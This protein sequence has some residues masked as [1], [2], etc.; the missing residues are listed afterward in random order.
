MTEQ[1]LVEIL[2]GFARARILVVG[3]FFLDK[4]LILDGDL[5]EVSL[6]T[7]LD[8]YQVVEKRL[9]PGAAGTVTANLAALDA[10]AVHALGMIGRDGEGRELQAG[11]EALRVSTDLLAETSERFTPTYTKP[12]LRENGAEREINRLDIKNRKPLPVQVEQ[13]ILRGLR[14]AAPSVD[15]VVVA[16]QAQERNC[17]V[18]TDAVRAELSLLSR[19]HPRLVVIADS[20]TRI[21]LFR[22]VWIKPNRHEAAEALGDGRP[23]PADAAGS[24]AIG[25]ALRQRNGR[26]VFVT[27]AEEG[28]VAVT[29]EGAWHVPAVRQSG[30]IDVVGAGDSVMAG[31]TLSLCAGARPE[32]AAVV[33]NLVA[34]ITVRQIG[35]TGTASRGGVLA[36][37]RETGEALRPLAISDPAA[38]PGS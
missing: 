20:R 24:A 19:G 17:G 16:D 38:R 11:L 6:E 26:P 15:A 33:G 27:M 23:D 10:A 8:A 28:I 4:Y 35:V 31:I 3:D 32:E 29:A 30:P 37:F 9:F 1:R 22:D 25:K 13:G 34:S 36:R 12:M 2:D 21:G 14:E 7:G 18:I 5:T